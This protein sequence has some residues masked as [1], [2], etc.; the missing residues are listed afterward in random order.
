V[1]T[2]RAACPMTWGG[3]RCRCHYWQ[4][5]PGEHGCNLDP[6][7]EGSHRCGCGKV[8]P[9]DGS[10]A[11]PAPAFNRADGSNASPNDGSET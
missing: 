8:A 4:P 10:N 3:A 6:D 11:Q 7:H 5:W 2:I 9:N 1:T